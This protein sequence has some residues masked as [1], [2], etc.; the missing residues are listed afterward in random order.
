MSPS[1]TDQSVC[2]YLLRYDIGLVPRGPEH[3]LS[4]RGPQRGREHIAPCDKKRR[5]ETRSGDDAPH[6]G[7]EANLSHSLDR[8]DGE[9][10]A[11]DYENDGE[12]MLTSTS[13]DGR[14]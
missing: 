5:K 1:V 8:G 10:R 11:D 4:L 12:G 2:R 7:N 13:S 14:R 3:S 9:Y 6:D